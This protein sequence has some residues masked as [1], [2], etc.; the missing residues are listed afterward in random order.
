[1]ICIKDYETFSLEATNYPTREFYR[2]G[3]LHEETLRENIEAFRRLV[4]RPRF[5]TRDVSVR[6]LATTFLGERVQFPIGVAPTGTWT[7]SA[8]QMT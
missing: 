8:P 7:A 1:M 5:L 4:I 3:A 6:Q 2:N